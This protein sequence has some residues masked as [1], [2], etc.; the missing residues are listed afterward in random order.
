MSAT[1]MP[2]AMGK[3]ND[4][5]RALKEGVFQAKDDLTKDGVIQRFEFTFELLWKTLK[6]YLA[7]QGVDARTPKEC[8]R[9]AFRIGLIKE[10]EAFLEML[11][12]RNKTS[13]LYNRETSDQIFQRI[14]D[15]HVSSI[16]DLGET[17]KRSTE[18]H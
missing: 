4:A 10:E 3:L 15:K 6:I 11:E 18:D 7:D 16:E 5:L 14:K 8:L 9:S 13:H 1:E 12:D 2:Y 17:L